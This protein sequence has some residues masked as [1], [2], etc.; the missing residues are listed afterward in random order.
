MNALQDPK[1]EGVAISA[2]GGKTL[3]R[4]LTCGS[5][6]DGKSTLI[7]RMLYECGAVFDDKL[8]ALDRDSKKF[9]TQGDSLDF[10]LLVDGLAAEREQG[11][12]IDVAYR[13]FGSAR[14]KFIVADTPGHEQY[15]RN[16]AT[17]ASTADLAILL[18]DARKGLLTQTRRHAFIAS[19]LRVRHIVL[20]VNK[21]DL[22]GYDQ[23][24]FEDITQSFQTLA[25]GLGFA[26]ITP[27]PVSARDGDNIVA[28]STHMGWYAGPVLLEHLE[29][30]QV[31]P[32]A[33]EGQG[34]ALP[35]QWVNR[36]DLDF[37]GYA[38]TIAAGSIRVGDRV[39]ILPN[40]Q[41]SE[42]ARLVTH[43]GD[44]QLAA[45]GQAVTLT[46]ASEVDISRGDVIVSGAT[47]ARQG[48]E[49]SAHVV[50]TS[51]TP[52]RLDNR[53]VIKLATGQANADVVALHRVIDINSFEARAVSE[54]PLNGVALV[55]LRVDR[56]I[57]FDD[58][59]RNRVLGGFILID[60][61]SNETAAIGLVNSDALADLARA[62]GWA[63]QVERRVIGHIGVAGSQAR[64]RFLRSLVADLLVAVLL[65]GALGFWAGSLPV[66]LVLFLADLII[67]S[68][69]RAL[70]RRWFR[71]SEGVSDGGGI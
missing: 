33:R 66:G 55:T 32:Q 8:G 25:Q 57:V 4:L 43:D 46:L 6:D 15:T 11:I 63:E 42:V 18:V 29:T 38:G 48:L 24:I 70:C 31:G 1:I 68:L 3:L 5:V 28:R 17:G 27:I 35:V 21:M 61:L 54:V 26:S 9:G 71:P 59:A 22:V 34:F 52:L 56:P 44:L 16:M 10:A 19:L 50:W 23:T 40:G 60:R 51:E 14:R 64:R 53:Y 62:S 67:R 41:S 12:T 13:Y 45:Q 39:R 69:V 49:L 36:P 47:S 2:P 37:R 30:V 20:A 58:Y 65:A 7:G